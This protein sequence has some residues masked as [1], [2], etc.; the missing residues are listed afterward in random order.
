[1]G[2]GLQE[3]HVWADPGCGIA[4]GEDAGDA[5]EDNLELVR[6]IQADREQRSPKEELRDMVLAGEG[7]LLTAAVDHVRGRVPVHGGHGG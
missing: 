4:G 5:A 7:L 6:E 2:G 3:G 1:M